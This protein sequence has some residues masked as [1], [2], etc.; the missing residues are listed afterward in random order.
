M[1]APF[2]PKEHLDVMYPGTYY[3]N[4]VDSLWR[5]SYSRKPLGETSSKIPPAAGLQSMHINAGRV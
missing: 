3:L 5:R 1:K 4:E 2:T